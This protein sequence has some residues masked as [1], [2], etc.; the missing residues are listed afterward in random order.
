[1]SE[2][3]IVETT[4]VL[5]TATVEV[6][7]ILS[8]VGGTLGRANN[9]LFLI[10]MAIAGQK[11]SYQEVAAEPLKQAKAC[12]KVISATTKLLISS[13]DAET[14]PSLAKVIREQIPKKIQFKD[15]ADVLGKAQ[16]DRI[17]E[18]KAT[19]EADKKQLALDF[20]SEL[21]SGLIK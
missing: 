4:E 9:V 13:T 5:E 18:L 17:A 19:A 14:M 20:A 15:E 1:M 10:P 21:I 16:L 6:D 3:E 12:Q 11:K 7:E 2:Q 8:V